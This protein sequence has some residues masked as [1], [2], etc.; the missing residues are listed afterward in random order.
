MSHTKS[1]GDTGAEISGMIDDGMESIKWKKEVA[2][3]LEDFNAVR[4]FIRWHYQWLIMHRFLPAICTDT[5]IVKGQHPDAFPS[6]AAIMPVAFSGAAYR[7]G[8]ATAQTKYALKLDEEPVG[9]FATPGFT[10]RPAS[11]NLDMNTMFDMN[12]TTAPRARPVGTKLASPLFALPFV[13]HGI[14]FLGVSLDREQAAKLALRNVL[15]DRF[16]LEIASGQQVA[17]HLGI[18]ALPAPKA[19]ADHHIEKTPLWFYAL[20][21]ADQSGTGKLD[22]V[23]GAIVAWV[24]L[25][26]L[27]LDKTSVWHQPNF[28][29]WHGFGGKDMTVGSLMHFVEQHR[30]D[31]KYAAKLRAG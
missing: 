19:L 17:N 30:G 9:F 1:A 7:F 15:R 13:A 3:A 21:E 29:P 22:G 16:A 5:A 24:L 18:P 26:L 4:Q 12:G 2:P 6:D 8:H 11:A 28:T 20:Q 14:D 23:G 25:R 27:R 31:I 10:R